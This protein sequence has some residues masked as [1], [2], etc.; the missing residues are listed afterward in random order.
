MTRD[1]MEEIKRHFGVATDALRS[2]IRLVA[3]GHSGL[4]RKL[5][6]TRLALEQE[7]SGFRREFLEF[8][9]DV[10][11]EFRELHGPHQALLCGTG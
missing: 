8:R 11:G 3:E 9:K 10:L 2:D 4:D 1:E 7:I 5:D 6:E